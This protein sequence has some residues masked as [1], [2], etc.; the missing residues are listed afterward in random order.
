MLKSTSS[1]VISTKRQYYSFH[2]LVQHYE[3]H[4]LYQAKLFFRDLLKNILKNTTFF[5]LLLWYERL[6]YIVID[7]YLFYSFVTMK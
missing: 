1:R 5:E 7:I 3:Y 4:Y 2:T 6:R